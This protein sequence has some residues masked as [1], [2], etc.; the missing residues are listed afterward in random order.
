MSHSYPRKYRVLTWM[1]RQIE[2]FFWSFDDRFDFNKNVYLQEKHKD[3]FL[4]DG[5]FP[6]G[7]VCRQ[8]FM[9]ILGFSYK[10]GHKESA[11][12]MGC[13]DAGA[14][15]VRDG[16]IS[17][18]AGEFGY[19]AKSEGFLCRHSIVAPIEKYNDRGSK[20]LV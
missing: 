6:T 18:F 3:R 9:P 12:F 4:P 11:W 10:P 19:H 5:V 16:K 2:I 8:G 1:I 15:F 17:V 14:F 7:S 20:T 13:F